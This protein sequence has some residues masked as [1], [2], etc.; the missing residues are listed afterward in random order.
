[1][2]FPIGEGDKKMGMEPRATPNALQPTPSKWGFGIVL[3]AIIL[4]FLAGGYAYHRIE[5][6]HI[7]Q[8]KHAELAAIGEL[9]AGQIAQWR[10]ER[11][12]DAT[13]AARS[14]FFRQALAAWLADP[15]TP[16]LR[17]AWRQRLQLERKSYGYADALLLSVDGKILL[18]A[19]DDPDPVDAAT[20]RAVAAAINERQAA[21]SEFYHC[22]HGIVHL[23]AVAPVLG[24]DGQ[25]LAMMVLHSDAE[26]FLFPL[27]QD[28]PTPSPS[29]ETLLVC[30]E[31]D[32]VVFL[33]ELRHRQGAALALRF[34]L[35]QAETP[36]VQAVQGRQGIFQGL[37][38]RG[39]NV[40]ADLRPV[41]DS[42][43]FIVAKV[44]TGE[45]L[46]EAHFRTGMVAVFVVLGIL[47]VGMAMAYGYRRRQAGLYR[48]MFRA[49]REKCEAQEEFKTT[50]Y[51]IGDAV[52]TTDRDGRVKNLNPV[53]ERLTGWPEAE[54]RGKPLGEVFNIV[55][56]E[57]RI[58][59]ENPVTR[60]LR[61][62]T[63]VE[64][65][66]HTL[67]IARD[68]IERSIADS[69]APIRGL[70]GAIIGVVLV[71]R[72][73]TV[74]RREERRQELLIDILGMLSEPQ[75]KAELIQR[76]LVAIKEETGFDAVGIR[77]RLGDDFPYFA[78]IGFSSDFLATENTLVARNPDGGICRD[79]NGNLDWECTCGLV[80][81]GK[82]D[83]ANP[84]FTPGGS[85]WTNNSFP[86]LELP[87]ARDP[88]LHPRNRCIHDGYATVALIPIR[89]RQEI[90][91]L[92]QLNHRA[93]DALSIGMIEFFEGVTASI[94]VAL[95]QK[96]AEENLRAM[97][98]MLDSAPDA[99]TVHDFDGRFLYANRKT[100]E[101]HGYGQR[102]FMALNLREVD[103]PG[104]AALIDER[105]QRIAQDGE[106]RFEV[107]HRRK[108]GME[109]PLEVFVKMVAWQGAPA[110]L[111]IA[112]EITARQQA[113]A[114]LREHA[115]LL[116]LA[117]RAA[118]FGGWSVDLVQNICHWSEE[119]AAIHEV[120]PGFS[121]PVEQGISVYAPEWREK[122]A[123]VFGACAGSGIPYDE[124]ME[125]ITA[126]GNRR[127]VRT[128]G[129]PE[130][131][132][133]GK[134]VRVSG[135]FQDITARR[136]V[137]AALRASE[138]RYR[139]LF[140]SAKDGILILDAETGMVVDVNPYL[141]EMLG[142]SH[143][144]FLGK[145]VW[146]LG[147]FKDVIANHD[148]FLELQRQEYIRYDNLPLKAADGRQCD[149]EF[150][151]NVYL[152]DRKRV[153][154][155]NIRDITERKRAEARLK[156]IEWML[157]RNPPPGG[158][159][160]SEAHDQGYGDLTEL[161]GDGIILKSIGLDR[162]RGIADEYLELL[163]TSSAIYEVNGD[164]AFGIFSSGW[165]RMLDCAS[166]KLC[167]TPDN[168]EALSSGRW[169]CHES[170]WTDCCKQAIAQ[171]A[172]VDIE[173]NGGIRMYAVPI[174]AH[175][176]VVGVMNFGYGDPPKAPEK[177]HRL[178]EVY[179]IGY[180]DLVREANAYDSRPLF[181]IE[182][183][184]C[185]N[186]D[187]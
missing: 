31:G 53:A 63:V 61:E 89:A 104:S 67:L 106:A 71:F 14:P 172:P 43:W 77:L 156:Q 8:E 55:N 140:E 181:I 92:L 175:G 29:A 15:E 147:P 108:D 74:A 124:E 144:Q 27:I 30:R 32:E 138:I 121:P 87:A 20:Q 58:L 34:P 9:K 177:L 11:L 109:L 49:E 1:M 112:T 36:A 35:T 68:G 28:W 64:L 44:D 45:I 184:A 3:A 76:I 162:L 57:T 170:C 173:C 128:I 122:I 129:Q 5:T 97:T 183:Q 179:K 134:I 81:T 113:E 133:T 142:Y 23:D 66:N 60:V 176:N 79:E 164:Y 17:E 50:L 93:K 41:P 52:I 46:A 136:R 80:L 12:A 148:S 116:A 103:V 160:Q 115:A 86:L 102:E 73:Q 54:A 154:Q 33:N 167:E 187:I 155:C 91:G 141:M 153:I 38:Y 65:A 107:A 16:D 130:R 161:N 139:R 132:A 78:Q 105:M 126:K 182:L 96:Q 40:L 143:E 127:W 131:D 149:V 169:L 99:I 125:I 146:E 70:D 51:S 186:V 137:E 13:Q 25:P 163:G 59:V 135:A 150:V 88:R 98:D 2:H 171:G 178:A 6:E 159:D 22:P 123:S 95:M 47:F 158:A 166:R 75:A 152:V 18:S 180:N 84:L 94:G 37:D 48:D 83:P 157:S 111:S 145:K 21:F 72:D 165:C 56:E 120:E 110:M 168:V 19:K 26:A 39:V 62:G 4:A 119:V 185:P 85:C 174:M 24:H 42:P 100:F 69:G 114:A 7:R 101:L 10:Q 118:S 151:S 82:T 117:G 90:V